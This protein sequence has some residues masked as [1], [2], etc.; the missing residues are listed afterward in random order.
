MCQCEPGYAGD[1]LT[2]LCQVKPLPDACRLLRSWAIVTLELR[3]ETDDWTRVVKAMRRKPSKPL[4][5][6]RDSRRK[7]PFFPMNI[8]TPNEL[9]RFPEASHCEMRQR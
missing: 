1:E 2:G 3:E 8:R 6:E 5:D 9:R 4:A 7:Y